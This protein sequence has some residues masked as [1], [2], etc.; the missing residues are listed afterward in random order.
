MS[1]VR[2]R[3]P[4]PLQRPEPS[5]E[6][7]AGPT[8]VREPG[9]RVDNPSTTTERSDHLTGAYRRDLKGKRLLNLLWRHLRSSCGYPEDEVSLADDLVAAVRRA[10]GATP[11]H[12]FPDFDRLA[13]RL[14][15]P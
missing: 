12:T 9:S 13:Q 10:Y 3:P 6:L 1:A 15:T 5:Q 11:A 7:S 2:V 14:T 4:P 8:L